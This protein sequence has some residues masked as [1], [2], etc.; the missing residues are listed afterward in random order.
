MGGLCTYSSAAVAD[1][2]GPV[3]CACS[4]TAIFPPVTAG[5]WHGLR[6]SIA[7]TTLSGSLPVPRARAGRWE[8][9]CAPT[10]WWLLLTSL[11]GLQRGCH[12]ASGH[13]GLL[14]AGVRCV[15]R[16]LA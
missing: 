2:W 4:E 10:A 12:L 1:H 6:P 16:D 13:H 7:S 8:E 3:H 15:D 9:V 5:C 14:A 11:Q